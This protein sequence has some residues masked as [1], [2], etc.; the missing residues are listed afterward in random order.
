MENCDFIISQI[1]PIFQVSYSFLSEKFHFYFIYSDSFNWITSWSDL[2]C[3]LCLS[4]TSASLFLAL[5]ICAESS[6]WHQI[7]SH[8]FSTAFSDAFQ[9]YQT[10]G[11]MKRIES[12][13][14]QL[15]NYP[16]WQIDIGL[17]ARQKAYKTQFTNIVL[18]CLLGMRR[19]FCL[20][21]LFLTL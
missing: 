10:S 19:F 3:F 2:F 12:A 20:H 6:F 14:N 11:T 17:Q 7:Q 4:L 21:F 5:L 15:G 8:T 18:D 1:S 9:L 16:E 13:L